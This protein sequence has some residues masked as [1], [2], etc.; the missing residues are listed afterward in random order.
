MKNNK[1]F[2]Y[3]ICDPLNEHYKIGV[4]K[5]KVDKRLLKL[6]TGNSTEL[7]VTCLYETEYPFRLEKMLHSKYSQYKTHGE[8][9]ALPDY[10]VIH[11]SHVCQK[12]EHIIEVMKENPF[13]VKNLK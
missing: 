5:D 13:F 2:V 3:L 1:G 7:H 4:T 9:F 6:Q 10:D 8:W 11:F 12:T